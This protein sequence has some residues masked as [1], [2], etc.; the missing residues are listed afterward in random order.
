MTDP[1]ELYQQAI[2]AFNRRNWPTVLDIASKLLPLAPQHDGLHYINGIA[3]LELQQFPVASRHLAQAARIR[4]DH[5][6]YA[7]QHARALLG[8]RKTNEALT[9]A[10][11][12]MSLPTDD[13]SVLDTLGV[14]FSLCNAYTPA[15]E[16][17]RRAV[18]RAP[19]APQLRFNYATALVANGDIAAGEKEV[20][21]C[22]D[23]DPRAWNA[24][25][26]LAQIRKQ[27]P[28][29]NHIERLLGL[30]PEAR[31]HTQSSICI[32]LALAKEYEDIG[33]YPSAFEHLTRGK[34]A[35]GAHRHYRISR[36]ERLFEALMEASPQPRTVSDGFP[37]DEPIFIIGMPR[38]GTTLV[39]RIISSHPEVFSAGELQNFGV[40]LKRM[41]GSITPAL[42][43][44]DTVRRT[45][46]IDWNRL[47]RE[48]IESTRPLTGSRARFID[49][50]PHNFLYAGFIARA[51]PKAKI[52]CLRRNPMDTCL[53]N[54]RQLFALNS[55]YY[56]YSYDLLD[57]GRYYTLFDRL[58]AH[59]QRV[60]PGRILE[61]EYEELV[62]AQ[63]AGSR[64][65]IDFCG[66]QWNDSCLHF[67][68]NQSPVATA[69]AIQV[70][71]PM[72]R[73]AIDRWRRYEPQLL[74]LKRLLLSHGITVA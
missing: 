8:L 1:A 60:V 72:N 5:A 43:D 15:V 40:T 18:E 7:V 19:D 63:E 74:E 4:P 29:S 41:S 71:E 2:A 31:K 66:L 37:S 61:V 12:A 20:Q 27:T 55:T 48:Y 14:V 3:A 53:S 21:R 59:W 13:P 57:T 54:F 67:H 9:E 73:R 42:I 22:L 52:I 23:I 58:I 39:E 35:A 34:A 44:D 28:E 6:G 10:N 24:H 45:H 36:D 17:F 25:L 51:L 69:S 11:R 62:E 16:A 50:L 30:L 33:Q 38:S 68:E 32:E 26:T 56:D 65:I 46:S 47:G 49:K 64:R 70:R